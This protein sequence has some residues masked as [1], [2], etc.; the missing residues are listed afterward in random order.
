MKSEGP[1]TV[2]NSKTFPFIVL[3]ALAIRAVYLLWTPGPPEFRYFNFD[4][5]DYELI[6]KN[7]Y[8][9]H[10]YCYVRGQPSAF[11]PPLYPMMI[12]GVYHVV[13]K[14]S[15]SAVRWLQAFVSAMT[16]GLIFCLGFLTLGRGAGVWAGV[17]FAVYPTMLYYMP[18][19]LSETLFIF[20][21]AGAVCL[22]TAAIKKGAT[23]LFALA[24]LCFG[25]AFLCRMVLLPFLVLFFIPTMIVLSR[26]N[27]TTKI[28]PRMLVFYLLFVAVLSP[29]V[30]RNYVVFAEFIPTNTHLGWVLWH[31]T[32]V[33]FDFDADLLK[34]RRDIEA[35]AAAGALTSETFFDAIQK[36]SLFGAQ[37]QQDGIR[38]AYNPASMPQTETE[39]SAFFTE[40]SLEFFR[41]NR[42]ALVRDRIANFVNF[43]MPISS[44]EGR[45]GEYLY[46][47]G[48]IAIFAALGL[49]FAIKKR[50][51][52]AT[53][54]LLVIV[55]NFWFATTIIVY[56]SRLKMPAD[57]ATIV[58]AGL[59][60]DT[61]NREKGK[62]RLALLTVGAVAVNLLAGLFLLPLKEL[63][64]AVF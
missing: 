46:A 17:I 59:A 5:A 18:K 25:I 42:L 64:K 21:L 13:G 63:A 6:G 19:F 48:V 54:P 31:N 8:E 49:Y 28:A 44:I 51:L 30:I 38:K 10:G 62:A 15:H 45:K 55:V 14:R 41:D 43:W 1:K 33:H 2:S 50:R 12:A 24:G 40:K 16:A 37:A 32:K 23:G 60:I 58:F 39:I 27:V 26:R 34:A 22:L 7:L 9:G 47:Y 4:E 57:I 29:W 11:R 20:I 3:L 35:Q 52:L 61:I 53:L 56:H 36:H